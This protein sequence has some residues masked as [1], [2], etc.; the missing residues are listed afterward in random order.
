V[1]ITWVVKLG[2]SLADSDT[3]PFWLDAL[4]DANLVIVP[5]GGPFADQVRSAQQRWSFGDE[6]AHAMALLAMGQYGLM[7]S[8]L[9]PKLGIASDV[10][11][12]RTSTES[13]RSTIWLPGLSLMNDPGI[14][15]SWEVTSDSLA[16]WLAGRLNAANLLLVKSVAIFSDDTSYGGLVAQGLV[17]AAFER[18]SAKAAFAVWLGHRQDH[19]RVRAGLREPS[20]VFTRVN[21]SAG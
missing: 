14:P 5:G 20:H 18:F 7:L 21:R 17:D 10:P 1:P 9:C 15:A 4:A 12:L 19:P 13:G 2:G 3:L 11:A 6:A 16:A 8:G